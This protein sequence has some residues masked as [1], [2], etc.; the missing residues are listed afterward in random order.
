MGFAREEPL[1]CAEAARCETAHCSS[2]LITA[3]LEDKAR[4]ALCA[5]LEVSHQFTHANAT[6]TRAS[7]SKSCEEILVYLTL[8]KHVGQREQPV[9]VSDAY[10]VSSVYSFTVSSQYLS[11]FLGF[12]FFGLF[13]MT[14]HLHRVRIFL[15]KE[16]HLQTLS[17][18]EVFGS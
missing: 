13:H 10:I 4:H 5:A 3:L 12:F 9:I 14:H 18:V 6:S 8:S 7:S 16:R 1:V 15:S 17:R 11:V 2:S